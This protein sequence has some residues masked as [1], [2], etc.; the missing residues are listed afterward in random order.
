MKNDSKLYQAIFKMLTVL[1]V[2]YFVSGLK[3]QNA[4]TIK[5]IMEE[6][7]TYPFS[8]P[9]P[10]PVFGKI[11]PYFRFDGFT[12]QPVKMHHKVVVLENDYLKLRIFPEIGGK[13]WSVV[14]KTTGKELFYGN[15]VIKFRDV[16][17][18]GPW[19]AGGIEINYGV[20]GHVPSCSFP[21]D[22]L[23]LTK[24][25]GSVSCLISNLDLLTRTRWT[26]DIN[27]PKDKGWFSTSSF[28][29]NSNSDSQPYYNWVNT[30]ITGTDDLELIL[31]GTYSIGHGGDI[32]PWPI[33]EARGKNQ[34]RLM[35]N[36]F[37]GSKSHHIAGT[38]VPYFG[39]H[40]V[41]DDF[42]MLRIA[43]RDEK[44]GKK[45]FIWGL[46]DQGDM[47]QELLT[48][49]NNMHLEV[50]SG[51]LFN[52][53]SAGSSSYTP[54]KQF[55]FTPYG[56]DVW[57][58]YWFPFK[59]TGGVTDATLFGVVHITEKNGVLD[60]SMSPLQAINDTLK[61]Y[62]IGGKILDSQPVNLSVAK[63]YR[64]SLRL[65]SGTSA[66]KLT[67]GYREIW[68]KEDKTMDRPNKEAEKFNYESVQ[69]KYL[70]GRDYAGM[71]LY[72]RAETQ[73]RSSLALDPH[74]IPSLIEMSRLHYRHMNY[75]SAYSC[76]RQAL[77]FDTYNPDANF[78]YG[79]AAIRINKPIDA[80]DGF[81]IA[82]MTTPLRSAAYTEISKIYFRRN[83][84]DRA[85]EYAQKSLINNSF[86]IEGLQLLFLCSK[87]KRATAQA[88][89]IARKISSLD[90][91]NLLMLYERTAPDMNR[92]SERIR[93]ELPV[94]SFLELAIWFYSLGLHEHS[95]LLLKA[96]PADGEAKY[97]LAFLHQNKPEEE[98]LL[99]EA[100]IQSPA[101]VLPFRIESKEVFE[102]AMTK[103]TNWKPVYYMALL[104]ASANNTNQAMALL[105]SLGER[106]DFSPFYALRARM[107]LNN[108]SDKERDLK[109]AVSLTPA[110]W[111][112][113]HQLTNYYV[114]QRDYLKALQ[115][116]KPFHATRRE[117]FPTASLCMRMLTYNKQYEEAEKILNTIHILPFEGESAGRR[118]YREIKMVLA[119]QA[120]AKG[121]IKEAERKVAETHVW[122]RKLGVGKPFDDRLDTRLEDWL[123]AL[124]A[125][126]TKDAANK[127]MYLKK[128]ALSTQQVNN[129]STLLQCLAIWQLGERQ[130]AD[131]LFAEWSSL[132]R[133]DTT[134]TWGDRFYKN[135]RDKAY[136]FD[137]DEMTQLISVISGGRD[138]RLF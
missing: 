72:D 68:S 27:L 76:A 84:F 38:H 124:I 6:Q 65:P 105:T 35:E 133:S 57:T 110:E 87:Q 88:D 64:T 39:A 101:Y 47:W 18:R 135:N 80:L 14:D 119:T 100:D 131:D 21:I 89:D 108:D 86:N 69:G 99:R 4:P 77:S 125:I 31:P 3:A 121:R 12:A 45:F 23:T 94:Q 1:T 42:G 43:E 30:G 9:N 50:Q 61:L 137:V 78:E 40:W 95:R 109:K 114:E 83:D 19:T 22:Y 129:L 66:Y 74:F 138:T 90:P 132:Q 113:I 49:A 26:V 59:G 71:R 73:I 91:F 44:V 112:Y 36:D 25:D 29:H 106:P 15:N 123:S 5:E 70:L 116:I 102:W 53:N 58:E 28:W 20:I 34:M 111:R 117:H 17:L 7:V 60:F 97:W 13:I 75:D 103:S 56:T 46:N 41:N 128:V 93:N 54:Y 11:Y 55:Y 96:A 126:R 32:L 52:Q 130:K 8:D 127:E 118:I 107:T 62:D 82:A 122:P 33:D 48:D 79:R 81:E 10:V 120:L 51:R 136:P 115:T 98:A 85:A 63:T 2:C 92:F 134:K 16:A 67:L 24:P 104:Q 37:D